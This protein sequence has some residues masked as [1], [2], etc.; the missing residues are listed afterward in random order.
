MITFILKKKY[1][2][3][4]CIA[5][6][7]R[8]FDSFFLL[9]P[10]YGKNVKL[11]MVCNGQKIMF[12]E[13]KGYNIRFIDSLNY[14]TAPLRKLPRLLKVNDVAKSFFPHK[15]VKSDIMLD[16][17]DVLPDR[18]YYEPEKMPEEDRKDFD[19]F[20]CEQY[21]MHG[22][23]KN[24]WNL[25]KVLE[26]YCAIDVQV[27]ASCM[28]KFRQMFIGFTKID[29]FAYDI[30]IAGACLRVFMT[31]FLKPGQNGNCTNP[32]IQHYFQ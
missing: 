1:R 25:M 28:L 23:G 5:H 18:E 12:I 16:Y 13:V 27:L 21:E 14:I 26:T 22:P 7:A 8:G 6:N 29:P 19:E 4:R 15:F 11:D 31:H 24:P 2:K 3:M 17:N 32:G 30:T 20:Y 10:L 9:S